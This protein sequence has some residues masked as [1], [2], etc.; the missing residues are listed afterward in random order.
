MYG[1]QFYEYSSVARRE[2][3]YRYQCE[4]CGHITD[5]IYGEITQKA[6]TI[7]RSRHFN[8]P[9]VMM[10]TPKI[11]SQVDKQA[12]IAL[13]NS[14]ERIKRAIESNSDVMLIQDEPLLVDEY[15]RMFLE[16]STCPECGKRQ[17]WYPAVSSI[18]SL[19]NSVLNYAA[20]F[21]ISG[22]ILFFILAP[23]AEKRFINIL[24]LTVAVSVACGCIAGYM[25]TKIKTRRRRDFLNKHSGKA[26][27]EIDWNANARSISQDEG[28]PLDSIEN[29]NIAAE[30]PDGYV[31]LKDKL[32]SDI[33]SGQFED[34]LL[35]LCDALE[36]LSQQKPHILHNNISAENIIVYNDDLLKLT[37]FGQAANS[38]DLRNDIRAV[39]ELICSVNAKYA[40]KYKKIGKKCIDNEYESIEE[41]QNEISKCATAK[42]RKVCT[43]IV[44]ILFAAIFLMRVFRRM[45]L[46]NIVEYIKGLFGI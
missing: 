14:I 22:A 42:R 44:M 31:T 24:L 29:E 15:N 8:K 37:N 41:L 19:K 40:R 46:D 4:H 33:T 2:F 17:S 30:V 10:E 32:S 38:R 23:L 1:G 34:Y 18:P 36:Y 7:K 11:L 6:M 3:R 20:G 9:E 12:E 35:Q 39:G 16:G 13:D 43:A 27:A 25:I 5:W 21:G 45:N 26:K 28:K